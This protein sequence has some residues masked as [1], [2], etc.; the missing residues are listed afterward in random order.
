LAFADFAL[1]KAI[2]LFLRSFLDCFGAERLAM[3]AILIPP[4]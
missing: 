2:Q 3:T 4:E 1:S